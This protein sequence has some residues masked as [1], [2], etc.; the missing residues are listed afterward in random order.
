MST[1]LRVRVHCSGTKTKHNGMKRNKT[2]GLFST[3]ASLLCLFP[4]ATLPSSRR[5][6][7]E[8]VSLCDYSNLGAPSF[9]TEDICI[10]QVYI[11]GFA[12]PCQSLVRVGPH[13]LRREL[14]PQVPELH[15]NLGLLEVPICPVRPKAP[16]CG[17]W[18]IAPTKL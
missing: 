3:P 9:P 12:G 7:R 4:R 1:S 16:Q 17:T 6:T 10:E 15:K 18:C 14:D 2:T 8:P 5:L 13:L 11:C